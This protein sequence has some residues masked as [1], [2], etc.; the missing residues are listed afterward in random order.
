MWWSSGMLAGS[1]KPPGWSR[2]PSSF[3]ACAIPLSVRV[4]VLCFSSTM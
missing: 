1:Y 3:S 2:A 4:T